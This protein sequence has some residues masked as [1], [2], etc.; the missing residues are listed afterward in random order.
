M[1]G[2]RRKGVV[3]VSLT[4]EETLLTEIEKAAEASDEDRLQF[5]REAIRSHLAK[6][7]KK[8]KKP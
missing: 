8:P 4:L 5:I 1:P 3:R 7:G 6:K 2:K